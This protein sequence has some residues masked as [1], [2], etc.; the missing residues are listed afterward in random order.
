MNEIIKYIAILLFLIISVVVLNIRNH[1]IQVTVKPI[2][3]NDLYQYR[4]KYIR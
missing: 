2:D 4:N 1:I 3:M